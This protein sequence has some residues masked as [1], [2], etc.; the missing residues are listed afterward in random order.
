M[1]MSLVP[2]TYKKRASVLIIGSMRSGKTHTL[3]E[4]GKQFPGNVIAVEPAFNTRKSGRDL[5]SLAT[6]NGFATCSFGKDGIPQNLCENHY[7][8]LMLFDEIHL[9]EVFDCLEQFFTLYYRLKSNHCSLVL[10][11]IGFNAFAKFA[12]FSIWTRLIREAESVHVLSC[13]LPCSFCG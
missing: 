7:E 12:P 6:E 8:K 4:I 11:G 5:L 9:Y 1:Q 3:I 2:I 10:A 13:L